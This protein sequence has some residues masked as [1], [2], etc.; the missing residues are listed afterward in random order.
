MDKYTHIQEIEYDD[1]EMTHFLIG[2]CKDFE[3]D[4]GSDLWFNE[5]SEAKLKRKNKMP[6]HSM[7]EVLRLMN[8]HGYSYQDHLHDNI[9]KIGGSHDMNL[10]SDLT[11]EWERNE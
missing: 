3:L 6:V 10:Y 7:D 9:L 1:G 8:E 2:G 11:Y 5:Y 4:L